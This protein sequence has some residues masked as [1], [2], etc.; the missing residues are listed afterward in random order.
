MEEEDQQ[1]K[2]KK[3]CKSSKLIKMGGNVKNR[4]KWYRH[5]IKVDRENNYETK[6]EAKAERRRRGVKQK[7]TEG[8][9][10]ENFRSKKIQQSRKLC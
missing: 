3:T 1:W 8:K 4:I 9:I 10:S 7:A 5:A 6:T 2:T